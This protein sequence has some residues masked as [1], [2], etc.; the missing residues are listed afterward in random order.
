MAQ[1]WQEAMEQ[2]NALGWIN[3]PVSVTYKRP[4]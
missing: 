1:E 2:A 4:E 3:D